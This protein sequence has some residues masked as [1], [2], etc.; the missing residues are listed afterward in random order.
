M[1]E[2]RTNNGAIKPEMHKNGHCEWGIGPLSSLVF[3]AHAA[4]G[5]YI[6][7]NSASGTPEMCQCEACSKCNSQLAAPLC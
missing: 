4:F 2:W 6:Q 3:V 5:S 1:D 7:S